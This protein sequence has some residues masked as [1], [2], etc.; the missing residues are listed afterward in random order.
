MLSTIEST[1]EVL[2]VKL[3]NDTLYGSWLPID[4]ISRDEWSAYLGA[5]GFDIV[6]MRKLNRKVH[7]GQCRVVLRISTRARVNP[8]AE[9]V[10]LQRQVNG[11]LLKVS[12]VPQDISYDSTVVFEFGLHDIYVFE[13][14]QMYRYTT[15]LKRRP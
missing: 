8:R 12:S 3:L 9:S 11:F 13:L 6:S 5:E 7:R 2:A 10:R 4:S 15:I 1:E 14:R